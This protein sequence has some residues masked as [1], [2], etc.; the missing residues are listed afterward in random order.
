MVGAELLSTGQLS[1][2]IARVAEEVRAKPTD[3]AARTFLFELLAL[4]GDLERARKQLEVL[5]NTTGDL[6]SGTS[7]YL[8]AIQA[9]KERREFFH[10]GPR[11][12]MTADVPY[13]PA[14]LEAIEHYAA[15]DD[16]ASRTRLEEAAQVSRALQG[17]LNGAEIHLL[18]DSHDLLGPFLEVVLEH[19]YT[20]IAWESIQSLAI[21][22]PRYLRDTVWT[23][24]SLTL[25][26]G[27]KGEA[28]IF[29]L[30]VDSHLHPEDV[31][32]GRRTVW[33]TN[34]AHISVAYGQKVITADDHDYPILGM[35]TLEVQPCPLAA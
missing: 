21:P 15:G 23:P 19:H 27:G 7:I 24:A 5:G 18:S 11:P 29:A 26:S 8:G 10:G 13:A 20:W 14:Y 16:E 32:L 33:E 3:P 25:R 6:A 34:P 9:E 2:A 4:N 22:E 1:E 31:K 35:R 30:Y 17:S 28:L 12:R